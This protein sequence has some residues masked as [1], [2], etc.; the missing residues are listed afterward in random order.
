[1]PI[2]SRVAKAVANLVAFAT[3][4][5]LPGAVPFDLHCVIKRLRR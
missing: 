2:S 4:T 1:V 5:T 3:R